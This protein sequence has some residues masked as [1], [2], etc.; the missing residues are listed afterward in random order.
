MQ[1]QCAPQSK[2]LSDPAPAS[3]GNLL[4]KG[5]VTGQDIPSAVQYKLQTVS[6]V[7]GVTV[8]TDISHNIAV[9]SL[10]FPTINL[11]LCVWPEE[12][13]I[14]NWTL[15]TSSRHFK[16]KDP[17]AQIRAKLNILLHLPDIK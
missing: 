11:F 17:G 4:N 3:L 13:A 9:F 12:W 5:G 15:N 16:R 1:F 14:Q 8:Y 10:P 7:T 2:I 6:G